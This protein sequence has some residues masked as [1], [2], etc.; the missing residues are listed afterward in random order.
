MSLSLNAKCF[1]TCIDTF[2]HKLLTPTEKE[3]MKTCLKN[4]RGLYIEYSN[5]RAR[6]EQSIK[7]ALAK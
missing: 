3:C 4:M 1:D 2:K 5:G 7:D 6:Y